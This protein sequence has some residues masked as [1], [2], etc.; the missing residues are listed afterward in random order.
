MRL[1]DLY[2]R[3]GSVLDSLIP[4]IDKPNIYISFRDIVKLGINPSP[5]DPTTPIGIYGYPLTRSFYTTMEDRMIPSY[6][7]RPYLYLF[8]A[9]GNILDL[10]KY[11][12]D[13]LDNDL[14]AMI[15]MFT[16]TLTQKRESGEVPNEEYAA[17]VILNYSKS[18]GR[19]TPAEQFW[20]AT[21]GLSRRL[22]ILMGRSHPAVWN[23][24]LRKLGYDGILDPGLSVIH[25]V[26]PSQAVILSKTSCQVIDMMINDL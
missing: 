16:E 25:K 20:G 9:K 7:Y 8:R 26:E 17:R 12:T 21:K 13:D 11:T 2:E 15:E 18:F 23:G 6:G 3:N 10:S 5:I 19:N 14:S 4:Y 1:V 22:G 24:L